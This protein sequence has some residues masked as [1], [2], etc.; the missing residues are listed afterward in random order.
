MQMPKPT[1]QHEKLAALAGTW[2]GEE[3]MFPA[4]WDPVGGTAQGTLKYKMDLDGFALVQE[5]VQKK[6]GAKGSFKGRG[7]IGYCSQ[8]KKYLW[9]WADTMGGV[10]GSVTRGE[11][12]G[13]KLVFQHEVQ[14]QHARY[15]YTFHKDGSLG[16]QIEGSADGAE[17][18][19]LMQGRYA[20]KEA[21][22]PAPVG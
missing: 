6:K 17:W 14:G 7:I 5:Y 10:P 15:T 13:Q 11:W 12:K 21:A 19:K 8:E 1:K 2:T 22:K 20:K 9:H 4:P 18:N 3:T 16:F